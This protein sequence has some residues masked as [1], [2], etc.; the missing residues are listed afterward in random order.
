MR[1]TVAADIMSSGKRAGG[2]L[3]RRDF[4][5]RVLFLPLH[6][7]WNSGSCS[8][9]KASATTCVSA[10]VAEQLVLR[11]VRNT[12]A[13]TQAVC[14]SRLSRDRQWGTA[15]QSHSRDRSGQ[16]NLQLCGVFSNHHFWIGQNTS[17]CR[18]WQSRNGENMVLYFSPSSRSGFYCNGL[19]RRA[20]ET[21]ICV[22][23][24]PWPTPTLWGRNNDIWAGFSLLRGTTGLQVLLQWWLVENVT[25]IHLM[26]S[27]DGGY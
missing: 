15:R 17:S 6:T 12:F 7:K 16:R 14:L 8:T 5:V 25:L 9:A 20:S 23:S 22:S 3:C 2:G 24:T 1:F 4:T 10:A 18:V 11:G 27:A 21:S 13:E 26:Q 19:S